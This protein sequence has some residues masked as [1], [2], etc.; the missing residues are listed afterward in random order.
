MNQLARGYESLDSRSEQDRSRQL[1]SL[2]IPDATLCQEL[3]ELYFRFVHIAFHNLFHR[4][5]FLARVKEASIPKILFFGVASL[6]ARFSTHPAFAS[7]DPW[8]RGRP[9]LDETKR[10]LDLE[11]TSLETIQACMLLASNASVEG[12]PMTESIYHS[13]AARM[14]T[15]L[16]LPTMTTE[17]LLEQEIHRRGE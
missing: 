1:S 12:D 17:T 10:L 3:V 8:D 9:Y 6:S 2:V 4:Q 5:T 7:T 13:I 16:D 14:A 11:N 15:L